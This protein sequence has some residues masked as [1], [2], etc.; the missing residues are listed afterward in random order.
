MKKYKVGIVGATG[1]VGQRL[2]TLLADH[3][4]F[5]LNLLAASSR[6]AGQDYGQAVAGRWMM[7]SPLPDAVKGLRVVDA[8]EQ[9]GIAR[10]VD[11]IFCA[12]S[13]PKA[14]TLR[15]E[16]AFARLD[17]PVIS[18]NSAN[19]GT[20]DVPMIIPEIN[21]EHL[22]VIAAQRKRLGCENGLI[23]VKPNCSIQSYVPVLNPL[24][25]FG[26]EAVS[27][28]T[29]QAVSG[30]GRTLHDW[31][32]MRDNVIPC[33]PGEEDKSEQEPLKIWGS[34]NAARD[35]I[36]PARLPAISAS[37]LRVPVSD[38]HLAAV[39]VKFRKKPGREEILQRW[40]NWQPL[41]QQMNLP[42]A[43]K[44]FLI[45]IDE[46]DRPQPALDRNLGRGMAV[47]TG[48][49]RE[50]PLMDWRFVCLSHNTL[51]GAA[52]G[53]VLTAELLCARETIRH[54]V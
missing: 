14:E 52:G 45:Y 35:R 32:E 50:D 19:R 26:P 29:F 16:E 43:P 23:V 1:M 8:S 47:I 5:D 53:S 51:R 22:D 18:N 9:Q 11:F 30:A 10:E 2:V 41:P 12:V 4:W 48:R 25:D 21:A 49:L 39:S 38:G 7:D 17:V 31:P 6:S 54:R 44:P 15:M 40:A 33:I 3:P 24:S 28:C 37:C 36:E 20:P 46:P 13:L 27:V 34:L 42:S